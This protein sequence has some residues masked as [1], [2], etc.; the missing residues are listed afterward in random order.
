M[1]SIYQLA[2]KTLESGFLSLETENQ[3]T[4]LFDRHLTKEDIAALMAL[5]KAVAFG[6]VKREAHKIVQV[7]Q[8]K[9]LALVA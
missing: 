3:I 5:Q 1:R 9:T 7:S 8:A 6:K 4:Y 2:T